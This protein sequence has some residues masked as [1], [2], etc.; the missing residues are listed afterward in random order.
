ME[1]SSKSIDILLCLYNPS[2]IPSPKW[3]GGLTSCF[4][5]VSVFGINAQYEIKPPSHLGGLTSCFICVSVF[6]INAQYEIKPP[7]HLG[8]GMG[9]GLYR[10]SKMSKNLDHNVILP[11]KIPAF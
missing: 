5:C 2:P 3:E 11:G 10:Q 4:I 6:G 7:S 8:E 1:L 9:E